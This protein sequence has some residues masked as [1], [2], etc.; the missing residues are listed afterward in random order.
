MRKT[1]CLILALAL[2]MP[3]A[4]ALAVDQPVAPEYIQGKIT[5][6]VVAE[7]G[8]YVY[9]DFDERKAPVGALPFLAEVEIK[10]L[11]LGWCCIAQEGVQGKRYIRTYNLSFSDAP[12]G[13]QLAIVFL[14][15]SKS[16]PMH[17]E[18]STKSKNVTKVPDGQ[19]VVILERG[20][21]FSLARYGRYEGYLQND[22]LSFRDVWKTPVEKAV[23]QDPNN[24]ARRTTV[25]IRSADRT[26]G[27]RL[28]QYP[29]LRPL[30]VLQIKEN[31]WA[32]V[33]T[34]DGLHGY[35]NNVNNKGGTWLVMDENAF[36]LASPEETPE[37]LMARLAEEEAQRLA[38]EEAKRLAEEEAKRLAEEE[39]AAGAEEAAEE[40]AE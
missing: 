11:G 25:N 37:Q 36:S 4:G 17:R 29:T 38:E 1:I 30:T 12:Y 28:K 13:N 18:P 40:T 23:L 34:E 9:D 35:L 16:L 2:L 24:P 15:R 21:D 6:V 7:E 39:A 20:D 8:A 5:A 10:T 3:A 32:E 33:E 19:Y 22:C 31:G 26:S 27:V 14:Q